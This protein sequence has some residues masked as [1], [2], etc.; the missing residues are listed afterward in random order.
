MRSSA[1]LTLLL[2]F[3]AAA[4]LVSREPQADPRMKHAFR[5]PTENGWTFVH[6][7]GGP[8]DIGFQHGYLLAPEIRDAKQVIALELKVDTKR[9]WIFF[10]EAARNELW[11]HIEPQYREELEGIAA[12][13]K[14]RGAALDR[15]VPKA[16]PSAGIRQAAIPQ[17]QLPNPPRGQDRSPPSPPPTRRPRRARDRRR[18]ARAQQ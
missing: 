5:R 4:A 8:A 10:R 18:S 11:P 14:A 13:L 7:E 1:G 6:L 9:S 15:G 2:L 16:R 3:G 17:D 12:G